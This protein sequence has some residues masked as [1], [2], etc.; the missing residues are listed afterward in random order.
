M[1]NPSL[2]VFLAVLLFLSPFSSVRAQAEDDCAI[3]SRIF[4]NPLII[5]ETNCCNFKPRAGGY[6]NCNPRGRIREI[7]LQNL[8]RASVVRESGGRLVNSVLVDGPVYLP[9]EIGN[10][11]ELRTLSITDGNIGGPIPPS[12]GNLSNLLRLVL[13]SNLIDGELPSEV[14]KLRLLQR[15]DVSRNRLTGSVPSDLADLDDLVSIDISYNRF[16][17]PLAATI[18]KKPGLTSLSTTAAFVAT[19]AQHCEIA[20]KIFQDERI[21]PSSNC[22]G[23]T[24]SFEDRLVPGGPKDVEVRCNDEQ[25]ILSIFASQ[26]DKHVESFGANGMIGTRP[27]VTRASL[28]VDIGNIE[29]LRSLNLD[30]CSLTGTIPDGLSELS[31]DTLVLDNNNLTGPLPMLAKSAGLRHFSVRNNSLTGPVRKELFNRPELISVDLSFNKLTALYP[32]ETLYAIQLFLLRTP[33][34]S[35]DERTWFNDENAFEGINGGLYL[36]QLETGGAPSPFPSPSPAAS[37][38]SSPVAS[39]SPSPSPSPA[40]SPSP[41]P[42]SSLEASRSPSPS[43]ASPSPSPS[44]SPSSS[45][46]VSSPSP[47]AVSPSTKPE[48]SN[49]PDQRARSSPPQRAGD[50]DVAG[51]PNQPGWSTEKIIGVALGVTAGVGTAAGAAY[52]YVR[53][54]NAETLARPQDGAA[55]EPPAEIE[56]Q[57]T[58]IVAEAEVSAAPMAAACQPPC[59]PLNQIRQNPVA[60]AASRSC[61]KL[62]EAE[63]E[64][65]NR[66]EDARWR[67]R[68]DEMDARQQARRQEDE[69]YVQA[70]RAR[71]RRQAQAALAREPHREP[72]PGQQGESSQVQ[73]QQQQDDDAPPSY[74]DYIHR[75]GRRTPQ[76]V[77]RPVEEL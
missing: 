40:A 75:L 19:P 73:Q 24:Y 64:A 58:A 17:P 59:L 72:E 46:S 6:I 41:S 35:S 57:D 14:T 76:I 12:I 69:A 53:K 34:F 45:S 21:I 77:S 29:T 61:N 22:C 38:S 33:A 9:D 60:E 3:A 10:L 20:H 13:R 49:E 42:S 65:L 5:P 54:R 47:A 25:R 74:Y 48:V 71:A 63:A 16:T 36:S 30:G 27:V 39:Q 51:N 50:S 11:T 70:N 32:D 44:A 66:E 43:A 26:L 28:P 15:L 23:H 4:F 67:A 62:S 37:P 55:T 18:A 7:V 52:V 68:N 8:T 56:L 1:P 31:L 2:S